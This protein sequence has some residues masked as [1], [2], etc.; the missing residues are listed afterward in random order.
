[1]STKRNGTSQ[2]WNVKLQLES[3][4]KENLCTCLWV[5]SV[6]YFRNL[7][8]IY[9]AI[10]IKKDKEDGET[11]INVPYIIAIDCA[12]PP[13]GRIA[14]TSIQ[15]AEEI[16]APAQRLNMSWVPYIPKELQNK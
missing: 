1:M 8:L 7:L 4:L 10:S 11:V 3:C 2:S 5:L 14:V 13:S 9:A 16:I 6:C 15:L 12:K